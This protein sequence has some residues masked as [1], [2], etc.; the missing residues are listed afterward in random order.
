MTRGRLSPGRKLLLVLVGLLLAL[1]L[2]EVGMR[3]AG[4]MLMSSQRRGS[5]VRQ[6]D[7][8]AVRILCLGESTS[9]EVFSDHGDQSWPKVMERALNR[10]PGA[11]RYRVYNTAVPGLITSVIAAD[12]DRRLA[13]YQPH[14][15]VSMIGVNDRNLGTRYS[16]SRAP[17]RGLRVYKLL[18]WLMEAYG[19]HQPP[20]SWDV[21]SKNQSEAYLQKL[22]HNSEQI[23]KLL[24]AGD[25]A[26]AAARLVSVRKE[27]SDLGAHVFAEIG[28]RS[29]QRGRTTQAIRVLM[30]AYSRGEP[31]LWLLQRITNFLA[32]EANTE[33]TQRLSR[34]AVELFARDHDARQPGVR[35]VS[36]FASIYTNISAQV[37]AMD[38]V[39]KKH[40]VRKD[41]SSAHQNTVHNYRVIHD[42]LS[43][44]GVRWVAM[45]Y[46]LTSVDALRNVFSNEPLGKFPTFYDALQR[47]YPQLTIK[48]R[49]RDIVFVENRDNFERALR[50]HSFEQLFSDRFGTSFGH[51]TDLGHRLIGENVARVI[52]ALGRR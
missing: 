9:A 51:T 16:D 27:H 28:T 45:A 49:Y 15:V 10:S 35:L 17:W 50:T 23:M 3:L 11:L 6:G 20:D 2:A 43:K 1:V 34:R 18:C 37:P 25:E 48:P 22:R 38:R 32:Y 46:P 8:A 31:D 42:K 19:G 12:L 21:L 33:E 26:A 40:G 30:T 14:L 13:Q 24:A 5:H 41:S 4:L 29:D 47:R 39:L 36:H 7:A 52:K 44:A